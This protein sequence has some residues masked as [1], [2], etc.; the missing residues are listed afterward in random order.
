MEKAIE[1]KRRA[2]RCIQNGDLDGALA[3]YE[4]LVGTPDSDPYNL[5]LLADLL[6]KKGNAQTAADRYLSAAKAY[7]T[8][9]LYKNGIAVCKKMMRL[10]LAPVPVYERL[11]ALHAL[12][13]LATEASL[14]Y[15]QHAELLVRENKTVDAARSLR[16]AFETSNENVKALERLGEVHVLAGDNHLAA[17]AL[18]EAAGQ[19]ERLGQ[20]SDAERSRRRAHQMDP[21]VA[22]EAPAVPRVRDAEAIEVTPRPKVFRVPDPSE[23]ELARTVAPSANG[24]REFPAAEPESAPNAGAVSAPEA[25][26][27]HARA[28]IP[29]VDERFERLDLGDSPDLP[30]S[31]RLSLVEDAARGTTEDLAGD[32]T[33]DSADDPRATGASAVPAETAGERRP[34]RLEN[35]SPESPGLQFAH[36]PPAA[37][38]APRLGLAEVE[39]L[40]GRAQECFRSGDRDAATSAL[41]DAAHAYEE[42][43]RAENAASIYRSLGK[44]AHAS[45]EVLTMWLENCER[46]GDR[47]EGA[48]VACEIGDRAFNAGQLDEARRWFDRALEMDPTNELSIRRLQRLNPPPGGGGSATATVVATEASASVT[49]APGASE[50]A[51]S[52]PPPLPKAVGETM[53]A[54]ARPP[55]AASPTTEG[56]G[57]PEPGRVEVAVGRGEAVTFDLGSLISE[58]QR[59]VEAQ[60]SGDAQSHYDLA[61]AYREM[62]LLEQ[63]VE[64][65]RV[66]AASP[67]F[68]ARAAEMIGRCLLDQGRFEEAAEEFAA[69]LE[70]ESL[71]PGTACGLS[72][73]LGLA[74]EAAGR[75]QEALAQ[76]ERVYADQPNFP[77]VALKIRVL[78]K[79]L[80]KV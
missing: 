15:M 11:A 29:G 37:A 80:E 48:Q 38:T 77:D 13:G 23:R 7:E 8:A 32:V 53:P 50:P 52:G 19:Y 64:S 35:H 1:I 46:R 3:E 60:L 2:Q 5:V 72:F 78:R 44:S 27:G 74:Y 40:L 39:R 28:G 58:F 43:G 66:A 18:V 42:L 75:M 24:A 45:A 21:S 30:G 59:G 61:M 34:P 17:E 9:G 57:L 67:V 56:S 14:Y 51:P 49:E 76:F 6:F 47:G 63:A 68:S 73:H 54:R 25:L 62:G 33:A 71:D 41:T 10:S 70:H 26:G 69:V 4:K 20:A 36:D 55:A 31:E 79:S 16:L 12:D 65:F 22:A